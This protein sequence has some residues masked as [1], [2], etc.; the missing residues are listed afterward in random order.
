[1]IAGLGQVARSQ[2]LSNGTDLPAL[3]AGLTPPDSEVTT[4]FAAIRRA[5]AERSGIGFP[6]RPGSERNHF[7]SSIRSLASSS[8]FVI[9]GQ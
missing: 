9:I 4:P 5:T 6:V 3:W 8:G 7:A 2:W 1:M